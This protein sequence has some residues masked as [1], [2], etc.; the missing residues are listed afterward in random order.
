MV[1]QPSA[2]FVPL[3]PAR[4]ITF[5]AVAAT[6]LTLGIAQTCLALLSLNRSVALANIV[7][8]DSGEIRKFAYATEQSE[9]KSHVTFLKLSRDNPEKVT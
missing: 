4:C 9:N 7:R 5:A 1:K 8:K 3:S 6:L 2:W